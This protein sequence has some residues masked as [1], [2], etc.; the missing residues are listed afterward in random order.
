MANVLLIDDSVTVTAAV[1]HALEPDGHAVARL[2]DFV[3]LPSLLRD[4]PVDLILLDLQ[5][6]G[7]SGIALGE[8]LQ[9]YTARRVPI[10]I[11]SERPQ[12][13]LHAAARQLGAVA[14]LPKGG[15]PEELRRVV[16][17]LVPARLAA[18]SRR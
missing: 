18:R 4:R 12:P 7:F 5:M 11:Y 14:A 10:V 1:R 8:F 6:P 9:R 17:G 16:R 15:S 3:E 2:N 13:E